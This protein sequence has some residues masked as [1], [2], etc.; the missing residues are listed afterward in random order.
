MN[1]N[2]LWRAALGEVELQISKANFKYLF[3]LFPKIPIFTSL[4]TKTMIIV[5]LILFGILL[6]SYLT[7]FVTSIWII[8]ILTFVSSILI[9]IGIIKFFRKSSLQANC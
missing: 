8:V 6:S 1:L 3:K 7:R 9:I 4:L 2:E 5:Q